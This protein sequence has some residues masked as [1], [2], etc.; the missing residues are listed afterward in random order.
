MPLRSRAVQDRDVS[1]PPLL[2]SKSLPR[3]GCD[4]RAY[5]LRRAL[6][7]RIRRIGA[8]VSEAPEAL[9]QLDI[10]LEAMFIAH[11]A[12][13]D[14]HRAL[15]ST[16]RAT[17][18]SRTLLAESAQTALQK[19]PEASAPARARQPV[20]RAID[21]RSTDSGADRTGAR[22]RARPRGAFAARTARPGSA[23]A[24]K[25]RALAAA[26]ER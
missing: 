17:P 15:V 10:L 21:A 16:D 3:S 6:P 26:E 8:A 5:A 19:T 22:D 13:Y 25:L 24:A 4:D 14:L 2:G 1:S 7:R 12:I 20:A 9:R 18:T 23:I 11:E